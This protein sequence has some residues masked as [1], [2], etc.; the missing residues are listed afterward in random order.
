MVECSI[1]ILKAKFPCLNSLRLKMPE[2]CCYVILAC[3]I[4]YNVQNITKRNS[5]LFENSGT[6]YICST[7]L[8]NNCR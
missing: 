4:L 2:Q 1:G 5:N 6:N 7:E 8:S 3:I